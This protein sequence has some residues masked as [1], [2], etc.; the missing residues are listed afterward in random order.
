MHL[1]G[2][3]TQKKAGHIQIMDHHIPEKP[4]RPLDILQ[5][6][7]AGIARNDRDNLNGT[8]LAC[9]NPRLNSGKVRVEPTV[10]TDHQGHARLG[11]RFEATANA[12]SIKVHRLF[13]EH[14]FTRLCGTLD[15]IGMRIC[16]RANHHG[17]DIR[18]R[19]DRFNRRCAAARFI[20]KGLGDLWQRIGNGNQRRLIARHHIG[21]VDAPDAACSNHSEPYHAIPQT[22]DF[23]PTQTPSTGSKQ[24]V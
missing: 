18:S 23:L 21:R 24:G 3:L 8:N 17:V 1:D 9:R 15:Q 12:G 5:R 20:G 14:G 16:W 19:K 13:T 6:R 2:F 22:I 10:K 7:R 4:A 11:H